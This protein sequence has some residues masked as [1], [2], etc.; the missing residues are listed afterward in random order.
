MRAFGE[1][2]I[3]LEW[4]A[5]IDEETHRNV[6]RY[7]NQIG[8]D[9]K[10]WLVDVVPAYHSVALFVDPSKNINDF[11]VELRSGL[12]D[13]S[14][15]KKRSHHLISIPV[16][17]DAQF[18]WDL[19]ELARSKDLSISEIIR[20][21]TAPVYKVYFM[22]FLPGFP[23]L[24]GLDPKLTMQRKSQP[25]QIVEKGSVGIGGA[26]TGIYPCQSPGGWHII[27]RTP[28]E[29]F[30]PEAATPTVIN[31]GDSLKFEAVTM[32]EYELIKVEMESGTFSWRK[33]VLND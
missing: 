10:D 27:G 24:G 17:Y 19:Q 12:T 14:E 1:H 30:D 2:T 4:P 8:R 5:R 16:C 7:M 33:E 15:E 28:L 18:G 6:L 20:L 11:L 21:H 22:G 29:L 9:Y 23:Y 3:L 25:R 13:I 26:Q 31:V 32:D